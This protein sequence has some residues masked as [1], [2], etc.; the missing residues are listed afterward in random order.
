MLPATGDVEEDVVDPPD[1][2]EEV[3]D[4]P[5]NPPVVEDVEE[6]VVEADVDA[7]PFVAMISITGMPALEEST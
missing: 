6:E 5:V 4:P 7:V 1:V 2:A 3:V